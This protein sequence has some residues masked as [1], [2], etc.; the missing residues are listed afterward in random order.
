MYY[1]AEFAEHKFADF[2]GKLNSLQFSN[3]AMLKWIQQIKKID[4]DYYVIN[5]QWFRV[6]YIILCNLQNTNPHILPTK[7]L[8][9]NLS[10]VINKIKKNWKHFCKHL[11]GVLVRFP[12]W[13]PEFRFLHNLQHINWP[14]P[15]WLGLTWNLKLTIF[16]I[17]LA[18]DQEKKKKNHKKGTFCF[19]FGIFQYSLVYCIEWC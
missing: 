4:L 10:L 17:E 1:F 3:K 14:H 7:I 15:N 18:F 9:A 2:A 8:P 11:L 16:Q 12:E 6:V 19:Y 5:Y 13:F